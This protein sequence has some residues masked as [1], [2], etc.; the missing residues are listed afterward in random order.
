MLGS[1]MIFL[2]CGCCGTDKGKQ[3]AETE[4]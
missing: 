4:N 3:M 2:L 1:A